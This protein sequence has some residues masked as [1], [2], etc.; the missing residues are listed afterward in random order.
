MT[1]ENQAPADM[2]RQRIVVRV[3]L[4]AS[5]RPGAAPGRLEPGSLAGIQLHSDYAESAAEFT[6]PYGMNKTRRLIGW[7]MRRCGYNSA[8]G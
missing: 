6:T 3:P 7:R 2:P 4:L 1:K 5:A 8:G